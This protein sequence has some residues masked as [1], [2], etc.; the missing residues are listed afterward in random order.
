MLLR[1]ITHT[2]TEMYVHCNNETIIIVFIIIII[3]RL[4]FHLTIN[5]SCIH[6]TELRS[7]LKAYL[8]I[9]RGRLSVVYHKISWNIPKSCYLIVMRVT[10]ISERSIQSVHCNCL[11]VCM[12]LCVNVS[13]ILHTNSALL[14]LVHHLLSYNNDGRIKTQA[15]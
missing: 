13:Q 5:M 3:L 12:Y 9:V 2:C 8:F 7:L 10:V 11:F 15:A 4:I 1:L 14:V 6:H